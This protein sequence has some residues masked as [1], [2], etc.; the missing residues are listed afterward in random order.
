M[1]EGTNG[2]KIEATPDEL[3]ERVEE[4]RARLDLLVSQLDQR[5]HVVTNLK[6]RV[7]KNPF[8]FALG[9][10]AL[11][12]LAGGATALLIQRARHQRALGVKIGR[13]REA[14]GR[15]VERPERVASVEPS[16]GK[17][18]LTAA[19]TTVASIVVRRLAEEALAARNP[20]L[21]RG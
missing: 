7:Q 17:K 4:A 12:G 20:D 10:A 1:G 3:A 9:A 8:W 19:A 11:V 2:V 21:P 18:V 15:A 5:R 14:L 6:H 13:L 16:V